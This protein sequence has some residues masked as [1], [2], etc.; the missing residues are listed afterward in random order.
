LAHP[1][2]LTH[3]CRKAEDDH[4]ADDRNAPAQDQGVTKAKFI[5][6]KTDEDRAHAGNGRNA[7]DRIQDGNH[8]EGLF[9]YV[10]PGRA[11][12]YAGFSSVQHV[13]MAKP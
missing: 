2:Q 3:G 9:S 8:E 13:L 1:A 10:P 5:I 6:G 11:F 12:D 7:A 4:R